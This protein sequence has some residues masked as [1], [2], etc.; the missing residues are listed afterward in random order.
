MC[1]NFNKINGFIEDNNWGKYLTLIPNDEN[2]DILKRYEKIWNKIEYLIN[3]KNNN[4]DN[5]DDK[6]MKISFN[7]DDTLSLGKK[8]YD[9]A[10]AITSVFNGNN[11]YYSQVFLNK[12]LCK[13]AEKILSSKFILIIVDTTM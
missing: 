4:S 12:C 13:L 1:I 7:S 2:K 11:K 10:I 6:Y 3:L 8:I 5:Y 9:I